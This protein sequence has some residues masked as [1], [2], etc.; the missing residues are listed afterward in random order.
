MTEEQCRLARAM[1]GWSVAEL[2]RRANVGLRTIREFEAGGRPILD[3]TR[4]RLRAVFT[5]SGIEFLNDADGIGIR[6]R[7]SVT[8]YCQ[9][10][11]AEQRL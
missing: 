3:T 11:P 6:R 1:L 4:N 2:S 5:V 8:E 9:R 10:H 7:L